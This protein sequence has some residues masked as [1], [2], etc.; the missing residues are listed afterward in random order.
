MCE[1]VVVIRQPFLL[2][3]KVRPIKQKHSVKDVY[4]AGKIIA[5]QIRAG[6][7]I[8]ILCLHEILPIGIVW[9]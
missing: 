1:A 9:W 5:S 8:Y 6:A 3:R 4:F 2:Y 7:K